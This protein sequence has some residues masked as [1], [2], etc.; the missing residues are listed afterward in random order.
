MVWQNFCLLIVLVLLPTQASAWDVDFSRRG[1]KSAPTEESVSRYPSSRPVE[2]PQSNN[3]S[4]TLETT[5]TGEVK[6]EKRL[7][8]LVQRVVNPSF[9][10]RQELVILNTTRGFVPKNIRLR[11][12]LHY[13]AHVVNVNEDKKNV[14]FILDGFAQHHATYF[15]QIKTFNIDPQQEGVFE[16]ICPETSSK[17]EFVIFGGTPSAPVV[18]TPA[19]E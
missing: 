7:D 12:G 8:T 19:A 13:T 16:F 2:M 14:S 9:F 17:G 3:S 18:R 11:K 6:K 5:H 1:N 10:D 4:Y 15:G